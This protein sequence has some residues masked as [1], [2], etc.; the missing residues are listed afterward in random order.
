[1]GRSQ[2]SNPEGGDGSSSTGISFDE[3]SWFGPLVFFGIRVVNSPDFMLE[4][5]VR[6]KNHWHCLL[7]DVMSTYQ[8]VSHNRREI[9]FFFCNSCIAMLFRYFTKC[10]CAVCSGSCFVQSSRYPN[11][12][13]F[14]DA[15]DRHH[16]NNGRAARRRFRNT[17]SKWLTPKLNSSPLK[18]TSPIGKDRLPS[19][20]FQGRA[21]KLWGGGSHS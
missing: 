6:E 13:L 1:M 11:A 14:S 17:H 16:T 15:T 9:Q 21:V 20:I 19:T 2:I 8:Q 3:L 10:Q 5:F 12:A 18:V 4:R 7:K